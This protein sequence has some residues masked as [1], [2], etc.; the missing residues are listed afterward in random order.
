MSLNDQ[1]E[2]GRIPLKPLAY[3]NKDLAQCNEFIIDFGPG[4]NYHMYIAD[5]NDPTVLIDLTTKIIKEI[6]P[7]AKINANQFQIVI[8]GIED[9]TSLQDII[10]FIFKRFVYPEDINGFLYDRDIDKVLD[11]TTKSVL[12]QNTDH[13]Y[14]LPI[15]T[16]DNVYD[17]NGHTLQERLNDITRVE[18]S[19]THVV[20]TKNN[21]KQFEFEYPFTNYSDYIM[22]FIGTTYIDESRYAV[23]NDVDTTGNFRKATLSLVGDWDSV[24]KGR[25]IDILFVYNSIIK[26]NGGY[27]PISGINIADGSIPTS[28]LKKV[29]D[30]ISLNDPTS[31]ATSAAVNNLYNTFINEL[32]SHYS[33]Y[34]VY[35]GNATMNNQSTFY[36]DPPVSIDNINVM[37]LFIG[38]TYI[39]ESRYTVKPASGIPGAY[40]TLTDGTVLEKN[41]RYDVIFLYDKGTGSVIWATDEQNGWFSNAITIDVDTPLP[42]LID[43]EITA[44]YIAN[45]IIP[46]SK[47][48]IYRLVVTYGN[49][50]RQY[51]LIDQNGNYGS[52]NTS[53]SFAA[54]TVLKLFIDNRTGMARII[55]NNGI[56]VSRFVYTC[57]GR[58]ETSAIWQTTKE[59]TVYMG[60][61]VPQTKGILPALSEITCKHVYDNW[62]EIY[63]VLYDINGIG[64]RLVGGYV[65]SKLVDGTVQMDKRLSTDEGETIDQETLI[66]YEPLDYPY[67]AVLNVYRNGVRLFEDIDYTND[68]INKNIKIFV[69]TE[70]GERIVFE[71]IGGMQYN[72]YYYD[73]PPYV[74]TL[75]QH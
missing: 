22:V 42:N 40:V 36:I 67:G 3:Q 49:N 17:E 64:S 60:P 74:D 66:S 45:V 54:G 4:G 50:E 34:G 8:E 68:P 9:P 52:S 61:G 10:N 47:T 72:N 19:R 32:R 14:I 55:S 58:S 62:Y 30:S 33:G 48:D 56:S 65:Q 6:L 26:S 7:N 59:V 2:Y 51:M 46:S 57:T 21:Q 35:H 23:V 11:P 53:L 27:T 25:R 63:S 43:S 75:E 18:L 24:E 73:Y 13:T 28:K 16:T 20:A 37:I 15:T 70:E 38:T 71:S 41:R 12:L 69:R 39:D 5:H 1:F 29:S 31:V 44:S